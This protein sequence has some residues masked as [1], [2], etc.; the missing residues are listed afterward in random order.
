MCFF[1]L[2]L[3]SYTYPYVGDLCKVEAVCLEGSEEVRKH[4]QVHTYVLTEAG[5]DAEDARCQMANCLPD[6]IYHIIHFKPVF[7]RLRFLPDKGGKS[8]AFRSN[9][10]VCTYT[11]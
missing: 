11:Q 3:L 4:V 5:Q 9:M 6:S 8:F 2:F 10:Y 1:F 7:P